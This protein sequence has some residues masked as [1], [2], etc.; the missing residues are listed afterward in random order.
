MYTGIIFTGDLVMEIV[1][2]QAIAWT[3]WWVNVIHVY[4]L[5]MCNCYTCIACI[6]TT[7]VN[8]MYSSH[9]SIGYLLTFPLR[10]RTWTQYIHFPGWR[11]TTRGSTTTHIVRTPGFLSEDCIV[12]SSDVEILFTSWQCKYWLV[13]I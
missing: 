6:A 4:M 1:F 12:V 13:S 5:C 2:R 9:P 8:Y 10:E 11:S 7:H 3:K